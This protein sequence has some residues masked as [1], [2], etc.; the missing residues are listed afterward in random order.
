MELVQRTSKGGITND[1]PAAP[2]CVGLRN[3]HRRSAENTYISAN[4][5]LH[6]R[7]EAIV[8]TTMITICPCELLCTS[9]S[10]EGQTS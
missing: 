8:S 2:L 6:M 10:A 4:I 9:S 7:T 5:R 3:T 1:S